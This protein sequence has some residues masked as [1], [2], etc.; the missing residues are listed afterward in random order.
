[1]GFFKNLVN[2]ITGG[3]AK[4]TLEVIEPKLRSPFKVRVNA[5]V[6]D[7]ELKITKVYMYVRS[8]ERTKVKNVEV[9]DNGQ[10]KRQDVSGEEEIYR[11]EIV[12]EPTAQTLAASQ[13]YEWIK[14]ISL[15]SSALPTYVG[16]NAH[17]EWEFMAALDSPGNDPD[18][19]WIKCDLY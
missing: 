17:H 8:V 3:G 12:I 2:K 15:P 1:M 6:S 9:F 10:S 18:S 14:E 4:V 11:T 13:N 5:A 16:R 7:S 19:G